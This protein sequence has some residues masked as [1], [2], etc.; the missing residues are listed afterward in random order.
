M[1]CLRG[2]TCS[3]YK[4]SRILGILCP[5]HI[6]NSRRIR[7]RLQGLKVLP[8]QVPLRVLHQ[9]VLRW[10]DSQGSPVHKARKI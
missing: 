7:L 10:V 8:L 4:D 9:Q 2:I 6:H 1:V 5:C 3:K